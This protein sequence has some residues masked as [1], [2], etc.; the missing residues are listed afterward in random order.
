MLPLAFV[1]FPL[2]AFAQADAYLDIA[3]SYAD[4]LTKVK[5]EAG[6]R[7]VF[8]QADAVISA[9]KGN[10]ILKYMFAG[11]KLTEASSVKS[12]IEDKA[13]ATKTFA[14]YKGMIVGK[15]ATLNEDTATKIVATVA[16]NTYTLEVYSPE[17]NNVF[18]VRMKLKYAN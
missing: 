10:T 12:G 14:D 7:V 1:L 5:A 3:G 2:A 18:E 17:Q 9:Q 11:G 8:E 13:L 4:V 6:M 16:G 15:G